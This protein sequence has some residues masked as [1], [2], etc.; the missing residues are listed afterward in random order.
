MIAR[1]GDVGRHKAECWRDIV[2][3]DNGLNRVG[4]QGIAGRIRRSEGPH[5]GVVPL[6]HPRDGVGVHCN[7]H[8]FAAIV[9]GLGFF[10]NEWLR[11]VHFEIFRN[12]SECR[13]GGVFKGHDVAGVS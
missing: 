4:S 11:A 1:D 5:K 10:Q 2:H 12:E 8:L 3:H 9:V 13:W 7:G 6:S